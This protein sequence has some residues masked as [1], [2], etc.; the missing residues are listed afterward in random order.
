M[1]IG[2]IIV[3]ILVVCGAAFGIAMAVSVTRF[4]KGK[5]SRAK[6]LLE[7]I[8]KAT[9]ETA[10][11]P[12]TLTGTESIVRPKIL[13]DFPEFDI[14]AARQIV[15][16]VLSKYFVIL[17]E[18]TGT[19]QIEDKC[20]DAFINELESVLMNESKVYSNSKVHRVVISDYRKRSDEA[21]I[22]FQAAVQYQFQGKLMTQYVY[23]VKYIYYL[24]EGDNGENASLICSHC[25]AEISTVGAK[26]CEYCG[27]SVQ[28][29]VE[30]TWK[31][32]NIIKL[33]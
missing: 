4:V 7:Q 18:R 10:Y 30:R 25:G 5:L 19:A 20:T 31:V 14:E 21:V 13:R 2:T 15:T 26:V 32:N 1:K 27:A 8:E 33:R 29:S 24:A 11:T 16:S 17:S 12:R 9:E 3:I 23:E 28:A 22:T 6:S